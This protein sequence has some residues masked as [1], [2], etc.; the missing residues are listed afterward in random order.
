[1]AVAGDVA[2]DSARSLCESSAEIVLLENLRYEPG[3][4]KNDSELSDRLAALADCYVDDAFGAAHRAHASIVG[5]PERLPSAAGLLLADEVEK[6]ERLLHDP[7]RPF[8]AVLGGA[9]V[10]DKLGVLENLLDRVDALC[11]GGAMAFTLLVARGEDVGRSLVEQ[12]RVEGVRAVLQAA[13]EKGVEV[14]LPLDV[15][16]ADSPDADSQHETVVLDGIGDRLGVDIGP[17]TIEAFAGTIG[18][19]RTVLW[20]GPMGIFEIEQFAGGTKAVAEAVATATRNGAYTVAG[21]GDSAAALA[22][23]GMSDAVSHLSTGG[24]ASLELLEGIDLPGIA[25]LRKKGRTD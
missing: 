19:A 11:V 5:V 16:A 6:L 3:E 10:S 7:G 12:D 14:H 4:E 25:V 20:N 2:G 17:R 23:L 15:V 18:N 13:D 21:G 24:G 1:V 22:Q 8:V 9:K